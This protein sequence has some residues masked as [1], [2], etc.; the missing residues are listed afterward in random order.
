MA[1][2][3]LAEMR[4]RPAKDGSH[5]VR[6]EYESRPVFRRGSLTGG[7]GMGAPPGQEFNF[8]P[9][10]G[11]ALMKHIGAALALKGMAG[12]PGAPQAPAPT[13]PSEEA[14]EED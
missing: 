1:K 3:R 7:M 4:I 9:K 2:P 5:N 6:H 14:P 13:P 8:G 12:A 11:A 10:D